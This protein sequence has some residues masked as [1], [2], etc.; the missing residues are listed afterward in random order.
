MS[1]IIPNGTYFISSQRPGASLFLDFTSASSGT[2]LTTCQYSGNADQ[3]WNV[4]GSDPMYTVQNVRYKNYISWTQGNAF[5]FAS[6]TPF[7]WYVRGYSG[8]YEFSPT[9]DMG[10]GWNVDNGF[11]DNN[12]PVLPAVCEVGF[13]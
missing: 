7:T 3:Q 5:V 4:A 6:P 13:P 11:T 9:A 1:Q 10:T 12:N 2:N 8:G